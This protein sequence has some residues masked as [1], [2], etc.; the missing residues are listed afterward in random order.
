MAAFFIIVLR[1]LAAVFL[2]P[3]RSINGFVGWQW[4]EAP[5]QKIDDFAYK[6]VKKT[7]FCRFCGFIMAAFFMYCIEATCS[8]IL[9][10]L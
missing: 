2:L 7:F 3:Y 1:Q 6:N 4:Y 5:I 8:R 10:A 9:T